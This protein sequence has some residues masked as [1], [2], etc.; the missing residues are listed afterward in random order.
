MTKYLTAT[1]NNRDNIAKI[2]KAL[3]SLLWFWIPAHTLTFMLAETFRIGLAAL[4]SVVL[5]IILG[6]YSKR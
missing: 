5:G 4:W 1:K 6:I 2:G 3:Y